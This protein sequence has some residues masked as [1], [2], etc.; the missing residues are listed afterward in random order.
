[1]KFLYSFIISLSSVLSFSQTILY[2]QESTSRTVQDPQTVVLAQGFKATSSTS[3]PFIAKIGP[4]TESQGGGPTDS[5]A[6]ASNPSGTSAPLGTSFHDTQGNIEVNGAGQL[7]FTLPITLP[8]GVKSVAPQVNLVYTSG[9]ANSIAGY[10]WTLS[11]ITAISRMG[12]IIE[13][14]GEVKGIQLDYSDYYSFNGQRLILKS[15]EYGKAGAEYVTEK[16]SNIKIRS[17]GTITGQVWKGPEYW[18]VTFE[19]GSQAWYGSVAPGNSTARTPLEYNIVKWKDAQG[20]YITYQYIQDANTNINRITTIQW[21][22]NENLNKAHFNTI[23]LSYIDRDLKEQSYVQGLA[24]TQNKLL[25][26]VKVNTNGNQFKRYKI[27]YIKDINGTGYQFAQQITEYNSA[28]EAANPILIEY[29]KS[30]RETDWTESRSYS[31]ESGLLGDFDGDGKIDVLEYRDQPFRVC[32][33]FTPGSNGTCVN[34]TDKPAGLYLVKKA[35]DHAQA[36]EL[37][38]IGTL[39]ATK[40][41]FKKALSISF[42]NPSQIVENK[43]GFA[44]YKLINNPT[45]GKKDIQLFVYSINEANQLVHEYTKTLP[46]SVY[47]YTTPDL[48]PMEEGY[49]VKTSPSSKL[50][51][52]DLDG[53]GISELFMGFNDAEHTKIK[54]TGDP[55]GPISL[56]EFEETFSNRKRYIV[57]N[58]D[59]GIASSQSFSHMSFYPYDTDVLET[60]KIG[61]FD[62][63][64][65]TDFL[66]FDGGNR[67]FIIQ[68][69]KGVD[70]LYSAIERGFYLNDNRIKGVSKRAVVGDFN[71]D[72]KSDLLIPASGTTADWYLYQSTGIA[73]A[74]E[75]KSNFA[76]FRQDPYFTSNNDGTATLE[77]TSHQAY[78][79]DRDGK[80]DFVT[81]NYRKERVKVGNSSTLFDIYYYNTVDIKISSGGNFNNDI[82]YS[83][84]EGPLADNSGGFSN[85]QSPFSKRTRF[86]FQELLGSFRINQSIHQIILVAPGPLYTNPGTVGGDRMKK[87]GFYDVSKEARVSAINHKGIRTEIE[88]KELDP[89]INPNF[90]KPIKKEQYPYIEVGKLSQTF[91]VSL[92]RQEGLKQDFRYRGFISHLQGR[93][94]IGFRQAARSSWYADGFENTKIWSGSEM[95]PLNGG[96]PV[97]EWSIRTNEESK[98]FP[99]DLSENNTQLLSFKSTIYQIDQLLNGQVVIPPVSNTDKPK[100]VTAT[101][102]KSTRTKDFLT[103]ILTN[104]SINYGDYY[105]PIQSISNTHNG[106]G[107]KTTTLDYFHNPSGTGANYYIGRPKIKEDVVQAYGDTKRAKEEYTYENNLLKTQITWNRNNTESITETYN[108]DAFGNITKTAISNSID[109]R[110]QSTEGRYDSKGRFV[111]KKMDNLGLETNILYNDWGQI[112]KQTDPLGNTLENK[113]DGWGKLLT[114]KTNLGGTTTYQYDRDNNSNIT[115]TQNDPDGGI[116]KKYTNKLGQDY[117][118]SIKAFGQG[119]YIST[120]TQ[121]DQLG[122]KTRESEPYFE[123]QSPSQFNVISYDDTVFPAKITATSFNGQKAETSVSGLTTTVKELNG[124]GRTTTKT[125]DALGNVISST[126]KGGTIQFSYNAAGEQIKAQYAENIVTTKYDPWG[127]KSEFNDPSNGIYKYEYNGSGQPKK[128]ISPKGTKEYTYNNLGQLIS[129]K[130]ISTMDGGEATN[131]NITFSYDDKGRVISKSGTSKGQ[132]YNSSIIYDPQGRVLSSSESSNGKYFIQKGITYDDKARVISY[133][134]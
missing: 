71:G 121:Y 93:G 105:L 19:D 47:D 97:K 112:E 106:Y 88:Y 78:D 24:Y 16:Y 87:I 55:N 37:T 6:G 72:G 51:E 83:F 82:R 67:P 125:T 39:D 129:Q 48:G 132:A 7:Q 77:R 20:N 11:G 52:M 76:L 66:R 134:K 70:H 63:D 95:D 133:E 85:S 75:L 117:K 107:I 65:K 69:K 46:N 17:I 81:F 32:E 114:S 128:I 36:R 31:L 120:E 80:S 43:Q 2:Q 15:G 109:S 62:G 60:Y 111:V 33:S 127:R 56:P 61:D 57:I 3:N 104:S 122:R 118:T 90:Y 27:G 110:I 13:K 30:S 1:M 22:G 8:P 12:K 28:N 45:S 34:P 38:Y 21:G 58:M 102:V 64:G 116:S 130:E 53:D 10:G 44:F 100:V 79:L 126:D 74:E 49:S 89:T 108:Y 68:F 115:I 54:K 98:I 59:N 113:Y 50:M 5:N 124:Y 4:A 86:D 94:T 123:G 9:V 35:L 29:E 99:V 26:E 103:G 23:E 14:D 42:K 101:V 40:E 92:I 84:N 73:F 96:V 119:R 18:E 25:S 91:V 41:E 131:K